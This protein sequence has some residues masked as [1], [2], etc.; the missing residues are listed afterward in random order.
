MTAEHF[1]ETLDALMEIRPFKPFTVELNT[2]QRIEVDHPRALTSRAG[3][4]VFTS[5]GGALV[6]F[7]HESVNQI[8]N[9]PVHSAPG[10]RRSK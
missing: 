9:V 5:P 10:R 6:I 4:A 2:G 3:H 8:V 1:E 7:D